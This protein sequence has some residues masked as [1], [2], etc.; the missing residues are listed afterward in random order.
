V[1]KNELPPIDWEQISKSLPTPKTYSNDRVPTGEEIKKIVNFPDRRIKALVYV[2]CSSGIRVDAWTYLR[3][4]HVTP[5]QNEKTGEIIAAKLIAY[6]DDNEQYYTFMTPEAYRALREWMDF[7]ESCGEEITPKSWLMRDMWPT[8][9]VQRRWEEAAATQRN[10]TNR[11]GRIGL[12]KY[13]KKLSREGVRKILSRAMSAQGVRDITLPEGV[14]RHEVKETHGYR[15]FFKTH[16]EQEM[17]PLN[18]E[19]LMGHKLGLQGS[20]YKPTEK[21]VLN[22]YLK[23]VPSLTINDYDQIALKKQVEELTEKS[24]EANYI[25]KGKLAEKDKELEVLR[26]R[27]E[28]NNDALAALSER[29]MELET[30][31]ERQS[32][33]DSKKVTKQEKYESKASI[34]LEQ[35]DIHASKTD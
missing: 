19:L 8:V 34:E 12:A 35:E 25:I 6:S 21:E 32:H 30:R 15:K 24:E 28:L 4:K 17:K 16:A 31:F 3:W 33:S 27:D 9:D 5:M 1:H 29:L 18:V 11:H 23:A 22:D 26:Q 10:N 13:P 20:Y 2:M 14:R 7:R